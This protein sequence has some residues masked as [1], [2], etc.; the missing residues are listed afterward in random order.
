M[1]F[2]NPIVAGSELVR[3]AIRSKGFVTG[4]SGWRIARDGSAEFSN[5]V[6]R[7]SLAVG[8]IDGDLVFTNN[9]R[10]LTSASGPRVEIRSGFYGAAVTFHHKTGDVF[11]AYIQSDPEGTGGRLTI[12]GPVPD[13]GGTVPTLTLFNNGGDIGVSISGDL[14]AGGNVR[15]SK[16]GTDATQM[17]SIEPFSCQGA[18]AGYRMADRD[19]SAKQWVMYATADQ[20]RWWDGGGDRLII[21]RVVGALRVDG[22]QPQ[23]NW[24]RSG[25][26]FHMTQTVGNALDFYTIGPTAHCLRL[27]YTSAVEVLF[28]SGLP[29]LVGNDAVYVTGS[30]QLGY[31]TSSKKHKNDVRALVPAGADNPLW[32]F[33]PVRFLWDAD[34][35]QNGAAANTRVPGGFAGLLAEEVAVAA[36]DA[37]TVNELGAPTGL[38]VT[39]LLAYVI[40]AVQHLNRRIEGNNANAR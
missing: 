33:R 17:G 26:K 18:G 25:H 16:F 40:D 14:T 9:G 23:L 39:V 10:I 21:D 15:A 22:T 3:E 36:P 4:V 29:A 6:V 7:G 35:V 27:N 5:V 13:A 30:N 8:T 2:G 11:P 37:V 12:S 19:N 34:L 28:P 1:S 38:D 20:L 24:Y 32:S 31:R